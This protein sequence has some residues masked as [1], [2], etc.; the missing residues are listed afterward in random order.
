M[1]VVES[2]RFAGGGA[3]EPPQLPEIGGTRV[4]DERG[5]Q[6][7]G[8]GRVPRAH[9]RRFAQNRPPRGASVS[10]NAR[11]RDLLEGR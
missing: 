4:H 1:G 8:F 3:P 10:L 11:P 6:L 7:R 2:F 5:G 9:P